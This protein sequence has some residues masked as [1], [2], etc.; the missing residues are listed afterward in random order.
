[1][2]FNPQRLVLAIE[3]SCD[4]TSLAVM[5]LSGHLIYKL[6]ESQRNIHKPFWGVVP[7]LA[8]QGH[9]RSLNNFA[10][11]NFIRKILNDNLVSHIAV[12]AGPG[13]G[14]CL[15][16]GF[17][18]CKILSNLHRIPLLSINHLVRLIRSTKI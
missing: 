8:A 14:S 18:F 15:N 1:M 5:N 2:R 16:S 7:Q 10:K 9:W 4:D 3:S 11:D 6:Q 13:I 12:T 17:E